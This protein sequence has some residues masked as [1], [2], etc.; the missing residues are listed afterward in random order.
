MIGEIKFGS[1]INTDQATLQVLMSII[2]DI[3]KYNQ[4][5]SGLVFSHTELPHSPQEYYVNWRI[6]N[7]SCGECGSY[8]YINVTEN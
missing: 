2:F 8:I 4:L 3:T 6:R 1:Y 5:P 7:Y